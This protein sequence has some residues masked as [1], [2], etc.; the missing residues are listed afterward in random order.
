VLKIHSNFQITG[1]YFRIPTAVG[2]EGTP[3]QA[4]AEHNFTF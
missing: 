4:E 2:D 3:A 1:I